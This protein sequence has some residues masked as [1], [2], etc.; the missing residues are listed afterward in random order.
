MIGMPFDI[1]WSFTN[2]SSLLLGVVLLSIVL[3]F[4]RYWRRVRAINTLAGR[5]SGRVMR[6]AFGWRH[7]IKPLLFL[8]SL[9]CVALALLRP[10]WNK[11]DEIVAQQGRDVLIALDIS[12]SMLATDCDPN[13][14]AC[15][16]QKIKQLLGLLSCE[17]VGLILFSGSAF[18]QCPL[19]TDFA[20]FKMF[21]DHVDVETI[22]SG[23]T[24]LDQAVRVALQVFEGMEGK[25]NKILAIFTDGEDFSSDLRRYKDESREKLLHI[26]TIGV[27]T[28]EGAPI[29]LFDKQGNQIGHQKD[30]QGSI[31][32][33]RLNEGILSTLAEDAGG[34]YV[35]MTQDTADVQRFVR[36]VQSFEKERLEDRSYALYEE[37]YH[38]FLLVAFIACLCEWLL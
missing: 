25:Q 30:A 6:N 36:L 31:V 12:R 26:F 34:S 27:G 2:Y 23:T 10:Q 20:A 37:Q 14:L 24:A 16:K 4:Y 5:Y 22:S 17:R 11:R 29:P 18:I 21:L 8:I 35:R 15:A 3:L 13:R 33:S 32:I 7:R 38:W 9:V 1:R 19:T 28:S